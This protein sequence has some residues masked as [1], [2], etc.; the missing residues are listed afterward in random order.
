MELNILDSVSESFD[1]MEETGKIDISIIDKLD[2]VINEFIRLEGLWLSDSK[3][4]VQI[5]FPFYLGCRNC[6][7]IMN[8]MKQRFKG[9]ESGKGNPKVVVDAAMVLPTINEIYI[10]TL[11]A[12]GSRPRINFD[13]PK[14]LINSIFNLREI[15]KKANM[16]P[17]KKEELKNVNIRIL[18][19][20]FNKLDDF[21]GAAIIYGEI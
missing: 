16:L 11:S 21:I 3:T 2:G 1:R 12:L 9:A 4:P 13:I 6:N 8:K 14:Q 17:P 10:R 18:K 20:E 7:L 19:R 5:T 15:A